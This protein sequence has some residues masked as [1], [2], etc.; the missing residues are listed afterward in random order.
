[1]ADLSA[2]L[3]QLHKQRD[4]A[5]RALARIEAAISA[6]Q[7]ASAKTSLRRGGR[8]KLSAAARRRIAAAQKARWAKWR[9]RKS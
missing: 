5:A 3:K 8:R 6:L 1:M 4:E 7:G 2:A 9:A